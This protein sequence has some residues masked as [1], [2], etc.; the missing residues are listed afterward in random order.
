MAEARDLSY[1]EVEEAVEQLSTEEKIR[2]VRQL[3]RETFG[4]RFDQLL[5]RL[6]RQG[7]DITEEEIDAEVRA[8]RAQRN[9][10]E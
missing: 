2:L 8:V 9:G 10:N 7:T 5:D 4:E 1:E 6:R 3:E